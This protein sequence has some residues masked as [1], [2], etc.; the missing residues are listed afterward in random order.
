M[1]SFV[2]SLDSRHHVAGIGVGI[3]D[4]AFHLVPIRS[5]QNFGYHSSQDT[6]RRF[7]HDVRGY[8]KHKCRK[9]YDESRLLRYGQPRG[10]QH[11][12]CNGAK[13]KILKLEYEKTDS[14][15]QPKNEPE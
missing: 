11:S 5:G 2:A 9:A 10:C 15:V 8:E 7:A 1:N 12:G 4:Q 3:A 13:G 14:I 6:R